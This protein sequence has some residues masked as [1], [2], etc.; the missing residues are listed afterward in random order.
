M[1]KEPK[2]DSNLLTITSGQQEKKPPSKRPPVSD[3]EELS[4]KK[5]KKSSSEALFKSFSN[6]PPLILTCSADKKQIKD[7]SH[8]KMGKVKIE[9]ETSEKKKSTLPPFDDIVDPNDS[10]VEENMSSKS[11]VSSLA[12]FPPFPY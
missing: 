3:S 10:D 12:G 1:S 7:K 6:A 11:D 8:G 2:P 9:S 5:R 4:A